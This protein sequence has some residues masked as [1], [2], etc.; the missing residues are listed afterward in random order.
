MID[1]TGICEAIKRGEDVTDAAAEIEP[2][3]KRFCE[4]RNDNILEKCAEILDSV[5]A[6]Y[7]VSASVKRYWNTIY[8][9]ITDIEY[10]YQKLIRFVNTCEQLLGMSHTE[11]VHKMKECG[12]TARDIM[13]AYIHSRVAATQLRLSPDVAAEAAKEDWDTALQLLEGKDYEQLFPFYHTSYQIYRHFEWIDFMYCFMEYADRTFVEK[14]HKSKRL[15]KYCEKVQEKLEQRP[16]ETEGSNK[17][18]DYPDFAVFQNITLQQDHV[19]R[20]AGRQKLYKGN[21]ENPHYIMS[22]HLADKKSGCGAA[23]CFTPLNKG[24][25]YYDTTAEVQGVYF[26]R[27]HYLYLSD[28]IPESRRC[29]PE[30]LPEEFVRRAYRSFSMLAGMKQTDKGK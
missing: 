4:I 7:D 18:A 19:I 29:A 5:D 9:T 13:A 11:S 12:W 1:V 3:I 10:K 8:P 30:E 2:K 21:E 25:E 17:T 28:Y 22:F 24:P 15:C 27:F 20:S 26:Y 16:T 23:I 6:L 14:K